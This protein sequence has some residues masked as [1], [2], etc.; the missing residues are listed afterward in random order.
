MCKLPAP[1]MGR[2]A[3][4]CVIW[5]KAIRICFCLQIIGLPPKTY[6]NCSFLLCKITK[7]F[8]LLTKSLRLL[9]MGCEMDLA[10]I[11]TQKKRV[12]LSFTTT[13]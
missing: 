12:S 1:D 8:I 5:H 7:I 11:E 4:K 2:G 13:R 10:D 6:A 9:N 3:A